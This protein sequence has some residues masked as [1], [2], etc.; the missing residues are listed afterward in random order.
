MEVGNESNTNVNMENEMNHS[1]NLTENEGETIIEVGNDL[2]SPTYKR[3]VTQIERVQKKT[4]PVLTKYERARIIG[5]RMQ[6]LASGAKPC[7]DTTH[8]RSIEE[9][10]Y[11]ELNKRVLP[12]MVKRGLPN[13]TY[14]YW[15]MEEFLTV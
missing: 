7:V 2:K 8:L 13:G 15:K 3:I 9:V 11:E 6:Q 10:A 14:E 12:F 1:T 5:V 4:I